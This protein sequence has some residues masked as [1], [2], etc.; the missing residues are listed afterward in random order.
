MS[1][2]ALRQLERELPA[3]V[4]ALVPVHR[5]LLVYFDDR[6]VVAFG[7]SDR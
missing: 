2:Q 6:S 4:L 7:P 5:G 3:G 1:D